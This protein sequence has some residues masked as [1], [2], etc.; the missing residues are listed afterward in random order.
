[1]TDLS[2]QRPGY[3]R[4][5]PWIAAGIVLLVYG[6][7]L[8]TP[9]SVIDDRAML[10]DNPLLLRPSWGGFWE[11]FKIPQ[12]SIY[13]P[14]TFGLWYV[15]GTT[16]TDGHTVPAWGFKFVSWLV[17]G[18]VVFCAWWVIW[19]ILRH[20]GSAMIGALT[21]GLHPLQ[22]ESVAWTTGTKDLLCGMLMMGSL[23][24]YLRYL[25]EQKRRS[26]RWGV[27]LGVLATAAKPTAVVLPGILLITDLSVRRVS[28][29]KRLNDL[30][31]FF[32]ASL[33]GMLIILNVQH[34]FNTSPQ[35]L[36]IRLLIALDSYSFYIRKIIWP[37]PLL[38]DYGRTP[39]WV[40]ESGQ[41]VWTWI[42]PVGITIVLL[43][44]RHRLLW[45]AAGWFVIPILPVSGLVSFDMQQYSTVTDHYVYMSMLGIGL[46]LAVGVRR[47]S[48][49][50]WLII[51]VLVTWG[52]LSLLQINRWRHLDQLYSDSL[53]RIP[54]SIMAR[55]CLAWLA[56]DQNDWNTAEQLLRKIIQIRPRADAYQNLATVLIRQDRL[57]EAAEMAKRS[58]ANT[59]NLLN[60]FQTRAWLDL[61]KRVNDPDLAL[62][63]AAHWLRLEPDNPAPRQLI[64]LI[65]RSQE[66]RSS[67]QP[68][69]IRSSDTTVPAHQDLD[70]RD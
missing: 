14:L 23:G 47:F 58:L 49:M 35:P 13:A 26:F 38:V 18:G 52:S 25:T 68:S 39:E 1:M 17:H 66:Y 67:T 32:P 12:Y 41:L 15:I 34:A 4:T 43:F 42:L 16:T 8:T 54:Q 51:A 46:V 63:A 20:R 53:R 27:V 36:G 60:V 30:W 65:R 2:E 70:S 37:Y 48:R 3:S 33:I 44:L 40:R 57:T 24:L 6:L 28:W 29:Q 45:L 7:V 50:R 59:T 69:S 55:S 56:M 64:D 11:Q 19:R 21:V 62:A 31:P 22:V 5:D 9:F 61:A 10:R